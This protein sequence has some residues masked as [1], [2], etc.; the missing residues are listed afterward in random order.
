[1]L[2]E[3]Y[4]T[5]GLAAPPRDLLVFRWKGEA[6]EQDWCDYTLEPGERPSARADRTLMAEMFYPV[7]DG[8][9]APVQRHPPRDQWKIRYGCAHPRDHLNQQTMEWTVRSVSLPEWVLDWDGEHAG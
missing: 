4:A 2:D 8:W 6:L 9:F 7:G 3:L 5:L 1:M